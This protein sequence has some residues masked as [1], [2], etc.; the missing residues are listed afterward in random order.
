MQTKRRKVNILLVYLRG[1]LSSF[2]LLFDFFED[3]PLDDADRELRVSLFELEPF[4]EDDLDDF[5][6]LPLLLPPPLP[7]LPD[8]FDEDLVG[9]R[10]FLCLW[11]SL[12]SKSMELLLLLT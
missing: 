1:D 10:E 2:R 5:E 7:A 8:D 6:P 4:D 3:E 9:E 11:L 12:L